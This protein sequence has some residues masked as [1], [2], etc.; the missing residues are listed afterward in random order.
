[1]IKKKAEPLLEMLERQK[2]IIIG[3]EID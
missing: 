3:V 2:P 1:M